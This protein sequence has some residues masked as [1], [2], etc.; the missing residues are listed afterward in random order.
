M[1]Q[2]PR[3]TRR[4]AWLSVLAATALIAGSLGYAI[5]TERPKVFD[6]RGLENTD[7]NI[8]PKEDFSIFWDA[9]RIIQ[10]SYLRAGEVKRGDMIYGAAEGLVASLKDPYSVFMNPDEAK[11]FSED[12]NGNFG[13]IGAE[14]GM[15]NDQIVVIAPLKNSPAEKSGLMAGD[16]IYE[17]NASST[18]NMSINDAVKKIRGP[19]G[20][21]VSLLVGRN[22]HDKPLTIKIVRDTITVPIVEWEMKDGA[23][24]HIKFYTFSE[25]SASRVRTA[26]TEAKAA[27]ARGIVLDMRNNPGG[28][29][30][31]AVEIAGY[32][33][34]P[35]TTVVFEEFRNGKRDT[36]LSHGT[37][38]A[39]DM[40]LAVILNAGS[41]SAS[42]ILAGAL[43]DNLGISIV[44]EKSFGK[45][46]VQELTELRGGAEIKLTIAHWILPKGAQIDKNGIVPDIAIKYTDTDREKKRD[47]QLDKALEIVRAKIK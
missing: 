11:R 38:L 28:Y 13:G 21:N 40:P 42:E 29:L 43:K 10:G 27:G 8:L 46:T 26:I 44:G 16:K 36:F 2:V 23:V 5:G 35:N 7:Q 17:I 15:K 33:M 1:E 19:K 31:A 25:D 24:A 22:G 34:N 32:F 4:L 3:S 37:P 47:P 45:G 12:I 41:A 20:T 30:D 18:I 39:K 9:W 14:I 6:V